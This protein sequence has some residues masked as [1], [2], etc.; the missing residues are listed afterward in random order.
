MACAAETS[1]LTEKVRDEQFPG[2]HWDVKYFPLP[3]ACVN[4]S[5]Y[6][7]LTYATLTYSCNFHTAKHQQHLE[8][9]TPALCSVQQVL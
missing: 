6:L 1:S 2:E 4:S 9:D 3:F 8:A 5:N 7:G